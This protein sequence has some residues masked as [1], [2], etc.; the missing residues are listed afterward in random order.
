MAKVISLNLSEDQKK[1]LDDCYKTSSN[2]Y[3][4]PRYQT[5]CLKSEGKST[6]DI[7]IEVGYNCNTINSWIRAYREKGINGLLSKRGRMPIEKDDGIEINTTHSIPDNAKAFRPT[8][9]PFKCVCCGKEYP[10]HTKEYFMQHIVSG[11]YLVSNIC[12]ECK[13][14]KKYDREYSENKTKLLCHR[15]LEYKPIDQFH[16][17]S[18]TDKELTRESQYR[19]IYRGG[20]KSYCKDCYKTVERERY[21][22]RSEKDRLY[23]CLQQR[24]LGARDRAKKHNTE[25]TITKDDLINKYNEQNGKCA[26][27]GIDLTFDMYQGRINTN[28]SI[29]KINP[30]LGY[31]KNNIQLVCMAVNQMKN[32][33]SMNELLSL[34]KKVIEHNDKL[35]ELRDCPD[36]FN[37]EL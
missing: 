32:D 16:I 37:I 8:K 27:T 22:R 12:K 3:F 30:K 13:R 35:H 36:L 20:R 29:D 14:N 34:C 9:E 18:R 1:E 31:T 2:I 33:L 26:L 10:A 15:C 19:I 11:R 6:E 5:I 7:A 21:N 28:I 4:K 23:K 24:W 17:D 25:F